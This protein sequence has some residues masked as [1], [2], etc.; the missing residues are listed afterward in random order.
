MTK[1]PTSCC[2]KAQVVSYRWMIYKRVGDHD[3]KLLDNGVWVRALESER[4][5]LY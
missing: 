3:D 1:G 2:D 5:M 4:G